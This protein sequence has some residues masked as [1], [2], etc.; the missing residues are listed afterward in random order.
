MK[1]TL[2]YCILYK[3][4]KSSNESTNANPRAFY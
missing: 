4:S 2:V 1:L 3:K